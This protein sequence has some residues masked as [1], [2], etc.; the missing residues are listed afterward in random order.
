MPRI[1]LKLSDYS[2]T[3]RAFSLA[4]SVMVRL[5][6][7]DP[8]QPA[9]IADVTLPPGSTGFTRSPYDARVDFS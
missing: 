8:T 4:G 2:K 7:L 3:Q 6:A 1:K 5:V 9:F